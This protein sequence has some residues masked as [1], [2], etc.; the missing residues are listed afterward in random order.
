MIGGLLVTG[1]LDDLPP[2]AQCP[3]EAHSEAGNCSPAISKATIET[4]GRCL[5]PDETLCLAGTEECACLSG[6]CPVPEDACFPPPDCPAAVRERH[7]EAQCIRLAPSEIGLGLSNETQCMCGCAGCAAVCDGRG[8]V[9]GVLDDGELNYLPPFLEVG[10][11]L[12]ARGTFGIYLRVRGVANMGIGLLAGNIDAQ[13]G[14]F[15]I[16]YLNESAA[17]YVISPLSTEF[18]EH[19]VVDQKLLEVPPYTWTSVERRPDYV[20]LSPGGQPG[21]PSLSLY[22]LDCAVP[23]VLPPP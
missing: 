23:F 8:P 16:E 1:C 12:P 9:I 3:G 6:T 10:N 20:V 15:D 7:P 22:E 5:E 2:P 11:Q 4:K 14:I 17:P 18:V 13:Q 21:N 19:V